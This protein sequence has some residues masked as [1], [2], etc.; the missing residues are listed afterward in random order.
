MVD[1]LVI[2]LLVVVIPIV[3]A[4]VLTY[5]DEKRHQRLIKYLE[6]TG[7]LG[8]L[9]IGHEPCQKRPKVLQNKTTYASP[10]LRIIK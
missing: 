10:K 9:Y 1:T 8:S 3:G 2:L 4:S 7:H 6:D 5:F